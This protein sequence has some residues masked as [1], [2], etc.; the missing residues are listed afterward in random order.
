LRQWRTAARVGALGL[1]AIMP[2]A[3]IEPANAAESDRKAHWRQADVRRA[4][5]A[6][7]Q[8]GL[9]SY[10]IEL[11]GDGTISIVVETQITADVGPYSD[12]TGA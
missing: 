6:A 2:D 9:K 7:E 3:G 8:A 4:I 11:S 10:R 1:A 12:L 5:A